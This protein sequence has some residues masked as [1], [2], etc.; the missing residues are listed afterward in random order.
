MRA[1]AAGAG[2]A[3]PEPRSPYAAAPAATSAF[4]GRVAALRSVSAGVAAG[5]RVP[6]AGLTDARIAGLAAS[7]SCPA[8]RVPANSVV[9]AGAGSSSLT[10]GCAE[11]PAFVTEN[12]RIGATACVR[13]V[14]RAASFSS[15]RALC[16][17]GEPSEAVSGRTAMVLF[18]SPPDGDGESSW[19]R[20]RRLARVR[21]APLSS[22]APPAVSGA[23]WFKAGGAAPGP[24]SIRLIASFGGAPASWSDSS[25]GAASAASGRA[26]PSLAASAW[27][28]GADG[29]QRRS[30]APCRRRPARSFA[31][32]PRA[33]FSFAVG[34]RAMLA[35]MLLPAF[36]AHVH[37]CAAIAR[38]PAPTR[39]TLF[40]FE[41]RAPRPPPALSRSPCRPAQ[42]GHARR[43][44]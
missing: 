11:L 19:P 14:D 31:A 6:G 27:W 17:V 44:E 42:P 39:P 5:W 4:T 30:R 40:D 25:A 13:G 2:D 26:A 33:A 41:R 38:L 34:V 9:G 35:T 8:R 3:V 20:M 10:A 24:A 36:A 29:C 15:A 21:V 7:T 12:A 22:N 28:G 16:P 37:R 32:R 23:R 43:A 18:G 1:V